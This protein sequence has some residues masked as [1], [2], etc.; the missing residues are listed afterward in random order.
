MTSEPLDIDR[1]IDD[2]ARA[3]TAVEAP[4]D[5]RARVLARL[6]TAPTAPEAGWWPRWTM[7]GAA[8]A[9]L[10]I[11]AVGS[12]VATRP[13]VGQAP[14]RAGRIETA[15]AGTE[16]VASS[17]TTPPGVQPRPAAASVQTA[18]PL[19]A[20]LT[21]S[22]AAVELSTRT[23]EPEGESSIAALEFPSGITIEAVTTSTIEI[24]QIRITP[25]SIPSLAEIAPIEI[26]EIDDGRF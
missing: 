25:I 11:A 5:M 19:R 7:A 9:I 6:T 24:D 8:A 17:S 3:L 21:T 4:A 1:A 22:V 13:D 14:R 16:R 18:A 23:S 15:P 26:T 20:G 12:W 2:A 10:L